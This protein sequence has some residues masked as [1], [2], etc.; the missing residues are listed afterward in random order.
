MA[1]TRGKIIN[2]AGYR[3]PRRWERAR[4]SRARRPRLGA[5]TIRRT[6]VAGL[7]VVA[8]VLAVMGYDRPNG[9]YSDRIVEGP[10]LRV[11]DGDT[12]EADGRVVRLVGFDAPET[13]NGARC[14][15]ERAL[16]ARATSRLRQ[17]AGRSDARLT[18]VPCAC[19]PGTEGTSSC[20]YGR[21][22]GTLRANGRDV[23]DTLIAEG[24]ARRYVCEA[25]RCPRRGS[26]CET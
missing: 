6:I 14:A 5:A 7:A 3:S 16:A 19:R 10:S 21:A 8:L 22:C 20:N 11:I 12:V 24:L 25:T 4:A 13:G 18:L 2:I 1:A 15:A 17:L 26:W 9:E 23:G